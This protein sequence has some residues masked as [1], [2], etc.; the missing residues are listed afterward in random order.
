MVFDA[1]VCSTAALR[2]GYYLLFMLVAML[3][4][5]YKSQNAYFESIMWISMQIIIK[6]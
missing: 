4:E 6:H 5:I 1:T 3:M 2:S